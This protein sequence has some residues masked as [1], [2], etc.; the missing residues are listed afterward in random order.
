LGVLNPQNLTEV[1]KP[2]LNTR[3]L[4]L[5]LLIGASWGS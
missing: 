1:L 5:P 2:M 3:G 4:K